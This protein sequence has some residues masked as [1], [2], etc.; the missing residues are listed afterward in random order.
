M[1]SMMFF[2]IWAVVGVVFLIVALITRRVNRTQMERCTRSV[3]GTVIG[4][5]YYRNQNGGAYYPVIEF[6]AGGKAV[7]VRSRVGSNPPKYEAGEQVAV[8]FDP[9]KPE[10]FYIG[11]GRTER[12]LE[13]VFLLVGLACLLV[14]S[15]VAHFTAGAA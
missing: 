3:T 8:N 15:L 6:D 10:R 13:K 9:D 7:R 12:F 11:E 4:L 5:E 1:F 2:A 14:G